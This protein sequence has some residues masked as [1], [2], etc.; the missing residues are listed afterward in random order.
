M[1][2]QQHVVV[3]DVEYDP[4]KCKGLTGADLVFYVEAKLRSTAGTPFESIYDVTDVTVYADPGSYIAQ[5][6]DD[7][8]VVYGL[9]LTP[10][11]QNFNDLPL[12]LP[13]AAVKPRIFCRHEP[14]D[15]HAPLRYGVYAQYDPAVEVRAGHPVRLTYVQEGW[16]AAMGTAREYA[17]RYGVDPESV[18]LFQQ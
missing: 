5:S 11:P 18:E 17:G 12:P 1:I 8:G 13:D 10:R 15:V 9:G 2:K 7:N 4:E 3:I 14:V 6:Q 16:E